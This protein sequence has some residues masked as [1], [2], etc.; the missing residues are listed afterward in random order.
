M[1]LGLKITKTNQITP[2]TPVEE[3]EPEKPWA[4]TAAEIL[5]RRG[6]ERWPPQC[7]EGGRRGW[8]T[9]AFEGG[10]QLDSGWDV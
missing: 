5:K 9:T 2:P 1:R 10:L 8:R 7:V 3:L 4:Q 6:K